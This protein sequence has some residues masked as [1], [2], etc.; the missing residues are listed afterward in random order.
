MVFR[1]CGA[2]P[3]RQPR[4]YHSGETGDLAW[5][6][7]HVMG[8]QPDS[9]FLLA[10]VSLGGNVLLKWLGERGEELPARIRAAAAISVPFDLERGRAISNMGS[11]G[12]TTVT[13]SAH[14]ARRRWRSWRD[15]PRC[16]IAARSIAR[17]PS[18][19]SMMR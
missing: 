7:D 9:P 14:Y 1:G 2:E 18:T 8:A 19:I 16:S 4:F 6:L 3:N 12:S 15:I 10:G 17:A 5:A 13:S 11:R